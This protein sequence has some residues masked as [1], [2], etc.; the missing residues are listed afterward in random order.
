M[1][2]RLKGKSSP[3]ISKG[4]LA[5]HIKTILLVVKHLSPDISRLIKLE[6]PTLNLDYKSIAIEQ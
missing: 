6:P 3:A 5:L 2:V 4:F 1:I